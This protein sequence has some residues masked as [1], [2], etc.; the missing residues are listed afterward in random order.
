MKK[1]KKDFKELKTNLKMSWYFVKEKRLYF[2]LIIFLS[3]I[4]AGIGFIIPLFSAQL[5]LK[6][7]DGLL[8][9]LLVVA[10]IMFFIEMLR[11]VVTYFFRKIF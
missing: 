6:L 10:I 7:T 5:I 11:N 2:I 8:K 3:L 1:I 4:L 9:E